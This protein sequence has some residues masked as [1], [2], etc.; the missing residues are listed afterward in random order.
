MI[1]GANGQAYEVPSS[2]FSVNMTTFR[3]SGSSSPLSSSFPPN[4]SSPNSPRVHSQRHRAFVRYWSHPLLAPRAFVLGARVGRRSRSPFPPSLHRTHQGPHRSPQ[5]QRRVPSPR[6]R[7]LCVPPSFAF[8][9]DK[10]LTSVG[11]AQKLRSAGLASRVDDSGASIGR[12]YAR[13]DELGTPFGVTLDFAC[14]S[15]PLLPQSSY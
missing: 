10:K 1:H 13:N 2:I 6:S 8:Q 9:G 4:C 12:R 14:S 11:A 5:R 7:N 3:E 15:L